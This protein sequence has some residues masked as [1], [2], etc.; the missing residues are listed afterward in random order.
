[1][2]VHT[3]YPS[4]KIE[5]NKFNAAGVS[6]RTTPVTEWTI[7]LPLHICSYNTY[8]SSGFKQAKI[9]R[10][11]FCTNTNHISMYSKFATVVWHYALN[12]C[13]CSLHTTIQCHSSPSVPATHHAPTCAPPPP[14]E[15]YS[16]HHTSAPALGGPA[17]R[18]WSPGTA[19]RLSQ[20]LCSSYSHQLPSQWSLPFLPN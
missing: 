10:Q 15:S 5:P 19:A 13:I 1:M 4:V 12:I 9:N 17:P 18:R 2:Y 3:L 20:R 8:V 14:A 6:V 16:A 7:A 11:Q